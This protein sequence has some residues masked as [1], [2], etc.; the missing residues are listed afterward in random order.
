MVKVQRRVQWEFVSFPS[1]QPQAP[2]THVLA[3]PRG[4]VLCVSFFTKMVMNCSTSLYTG[5]DYLAKQNDSVSKRWKQP[6][7][8][9]TDEWTSTVWFIQT[10]ECDSAFERKDSDT[11]CSVDGAGGEMSQSED[12]CCDRITRGPWRSETHRHRKWTG[13]GEGWAVRV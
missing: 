12:E 4:V 11:C 13:L 6:K 5:G 3:P 2:L 9:W 10:V 8:L 7:C 1:A